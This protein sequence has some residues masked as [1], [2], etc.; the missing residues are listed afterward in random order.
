MSDYFHSHVMLDNPEVRQTTDGVWHIW[1]CVL[2]GESVGKIE[3][4]TNRRHYEK[5]Y[6]T[7]VR[8]LSKDWER[9]TRVG[10][11]DTLIEAKAALLEPAREYLTELEQNRQESEIPVHLL[12]SAD[13]EFYPTPPELAGQLSAELRLYLSYKCRQD[14]LRLLLDH[15]LESQ[16]QRLDNGSATD[17]HEI[18][19]GFWAVHNEREDIDVSDY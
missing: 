12:P 4:R 1:N 10:W 5:P 7:S 15:L 6:E 3:M 17:T 19:K 13:Y 18:S 8:V 14:G 2:C 9:F 11:Y 16:I